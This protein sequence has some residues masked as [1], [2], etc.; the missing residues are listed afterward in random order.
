MTSKERAALRSLSNND[1]PI[2]LIGKDGLTDDVIT[3]VR[4]ALN[5]REI[6][7][8][9]ILNNSDE[10]AKD[11]MAS[12]CECLNAEAISVVGN[13]GVIYKYSQKK[14]KH[15]ID[16]ITPQKEIVKKAPSTGH[17]PGCKAK[18]RRERERQEEALK[19]EYIRAKIKESRG[20]YV[21]K[22]PVKPRSMKAN[23]KAGAK[24]DAKSVKNASFKGSRSQSAKVKVGA[25]NTRVGKTGAK[26]RIQKSLKGK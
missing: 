1:K 6:I 25:K 7:K 15:I 24:K 22:K 21:A 13:V 8:F 4:N 11:V 17:K 20:E 16:E 26:S 2:V 14:K 12:L 3:S 18:I 23:Q 10:T 5:T 19:Q 9:K